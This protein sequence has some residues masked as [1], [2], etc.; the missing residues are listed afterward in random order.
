MKFYREER[1]S[2]EKLRKSGSDVLSKREVTFFEWHSMKMN[3]REIRRFGK[4]FYTVRVTG[5][6]PIIS[7]CV[8][9]Q[10]KKGRL[11]IALYSI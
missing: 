2:M 11:G 8:G 5:F 1:F 6:L 9:I 4:K 7:S 3:V 10:G